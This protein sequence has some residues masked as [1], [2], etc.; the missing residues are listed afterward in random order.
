MDNEDLSTTSYTKNYWDCPRCGDVNG[1]TDADLA[2]EE[3]C[4]SCG[5]IVE[6]N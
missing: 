5:A 1:D 6:V 3:K 2:G 4:E